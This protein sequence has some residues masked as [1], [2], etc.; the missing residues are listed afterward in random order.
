MKKVAIET[1]GCKINQYESACIIDP[2]LK[3]GYQLVGF[4]ADADV[5]IIN[6]CTVTNRTDSKAEMPSEKYWKE[7]SIIPE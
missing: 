4:N 1:F 7:K 6:S 3:N 2:F 5:Y